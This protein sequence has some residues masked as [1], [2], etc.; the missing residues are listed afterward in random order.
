MHAGPRVGARYLGIN[1]KRGTIDLAELPSAFKVLT[2][3]ETE[4]LL[5]IY[6]E[7]IRAIIA[8]QEDAR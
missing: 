8:R 4:D 5:C 2:P 3:Q 1:G 6:K 7:S